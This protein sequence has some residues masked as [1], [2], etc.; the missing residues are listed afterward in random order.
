MA[1]TLLL[2]DKLFLDQLEKERSHPSAQMAL[3]KCQILQNSNGSFGVDK[4]FYKRNLQ[5]Y[6]QMI[7]DIHGHGVQPKTYQSTTYFPMLYVTW[8]LMDLP[9]FLNN[10]T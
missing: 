3:G 8:I 7:A 6:L 5:K 2:F 4:Y 10:I 9:D 1:W